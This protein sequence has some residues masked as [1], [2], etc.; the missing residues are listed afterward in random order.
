MAKK[1]KKRHKG[2]IREKSSYI[3]FF[4]KNVKCRHFSFFVKKPLKYKYILKM[5]KK[6]GSIYGRRPVGGYRVPPI[7]GGGTCRYHLL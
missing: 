4:Y 3:G 5:V 1:W 6:G 2:K 7:C